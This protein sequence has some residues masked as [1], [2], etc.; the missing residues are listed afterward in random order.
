[1]KNKSS[2][3]IVSGNEEQ[4]RLLKSSKQFKKLDRQNPILGGDSTDYEA[5]TNYQ[6]KSYGTTINLKE[7]SP[8]IYRA[9]VNEA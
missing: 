1:M 8:G 5:A 3:N 6:P 2:Y 9:Q 4:E 7:S